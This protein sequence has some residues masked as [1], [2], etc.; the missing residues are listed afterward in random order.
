MRGACDEE[1]GGVCGVEEGWR[2][3][4][5]VEGWG[6]A[7]AWGVAEVWGRSEEHTSELQSPVSISY[8]VFCL[9]KK[10]LI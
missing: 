8:A 3:G 9:K 6:V 2:C 10:T 1:W 4:M 5:G 7:E